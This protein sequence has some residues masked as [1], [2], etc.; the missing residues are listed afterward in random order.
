MG[1]KGTII[2]GYRERV[3]GLLMSGF[4]ATAIFTDGRTGCYN[5]GLT[6]I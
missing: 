6:I 1:M 3:R 5:S 2:P 4:Q